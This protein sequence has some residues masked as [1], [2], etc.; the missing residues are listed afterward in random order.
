MV[1]SLDEPF[2]ASNENVRLASIIEASRP[3][4]S[5]IIAPGMNEYILS[6]DDVLSNFRS[7]VGETDKLDA[8]VQ[9]SSS[10]EWNTASS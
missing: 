1:A 10:D 7:D 6:I 2:L 9:Q 5:R 4:K 8:V 3:N